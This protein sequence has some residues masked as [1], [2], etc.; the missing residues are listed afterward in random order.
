VVLVGGALGGVGTLC[1]TIGQSR[2][3]SQ[4]MR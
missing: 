4:E 3:P 1:R 2:V